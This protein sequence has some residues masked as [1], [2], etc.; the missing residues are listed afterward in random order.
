M[1]SQSAIAPAA[2]GQRGRYPGRLSLRGAP[3]G[4]WA[5]PP[6]TFEAQGR[7]AAYVAHELRA[8]VAF[9]RALVEVA[10]A[11][12]AADTTALREMGERVIASCERQQQLI[13]A[14]LDLTRSRCGPKRREPVD[15]STITA[16]ALRAHDLGRLERVVVLEPAWTTGDPGLLARLV[17][18]LVSNAIHHNLS[19]GRIEIATRT[20]SRRAVLSV[21]NTGPLIPPGE[22][23]RL[24]QP[25]QRLASYPTSAV[26]G[27]GLGLA[28]VQAIADAH[29]ALISA[30]ARAGGGLEIHVGFPPTV[31]RRP[32]LRT[33]SR[34]AERPSLGEP[35]GKPMA[36]RGAG[37]RS[38]E[39]SRRRPL[40]IAL[41]AV[42][43]AVALAA[44]GSSSP[45]K[46]SDGPTGQ[47][48]LAG[49][50]AF[51]KCM[52]S[53]G[54]PNFPDPHVSGNSI[55]IL[56]GGPG[57]DQQS[58]AFTSAQQSCEHLLPSGVAP[59]QQQIAQ[60][61]AQLLRISRC[62]RSHG[63]PGFPDPTTSPPTSRAGYSA[64]TSNGGAWLAIPSSVDVNSPAFQRA[65]AACTLGPV[66]STAP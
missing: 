11:D 39:C 49:A 36:L 58:P 51:S 52:R 26:E 30:R 1:S 29:D 22:L 21:A 64:I 20:E 18:N 14:L 40:P 42:S 12:P 10:L 60:K 2:D 17:A 7:F 24:F 27:A 61:L 31:D 63:I 33:A 32:A 19:R 9:Q 15:L 59:R 65:A 50:L 55:Q 4:G 54:V 44:C 34:S 43:C 35:E 23:Q 62:M 46:A 48:K 6:T 53:H 38:T 41:A 8:P 45:T 57:I 66:G 5:A 3:G 56:G 25:F 16:A 47:R 28:I 13:E 37:N